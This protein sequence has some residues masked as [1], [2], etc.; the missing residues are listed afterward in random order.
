MLIGLVLSLVTRNSRFMKLNRRLREL[1]DSNKKEL[2]LL[3]LLCFS[4][5]TNAQSKE[6]PM[7]EAVQ[8]FAVSTEH[9]DKFGAL[10]VQSSNGRMIPVN[11][12]SS[13]ILRK[14]HKSDKIGSLNSDQ[15]LLSLLAM[16]D[17]W[18]RVPLIAIS[19]SEL[20]GFYNLTEGQSAYIEMFDSNGNY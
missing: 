10:P 8:K 7:I 15:F 1:I 16:A 4:L 12:F 3:V 17:M 2:T 13:E 5:T 18:M 20:A 6:N 11:T 19:N 9:A 14:L